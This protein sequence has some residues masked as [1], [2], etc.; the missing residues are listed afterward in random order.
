MARDIRQALK[1]ARGLGLRLATRTVT[2]GNLPDLS[3]RA[4]RP[5]PLRERQAVPRMI[6]AC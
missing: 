5:R 6:S 3:D 2:C 1:P 4:S